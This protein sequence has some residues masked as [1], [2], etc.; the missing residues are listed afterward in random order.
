MTRHGRAASCAAALVLSF[1]LLAACHSLPAGTA[2]P[3]PSSRSAAVANVRN[4]LTQ[5]VL[6]PRVAVTARGIYVAW[7]LS[8]PG[9]EVTRSELARIN[10]ATGQVTASRTV[11]SDVVQVVAAAGSLWAA[12]QLAGHRTLL[13]LDPVTLASTGAWTQA[14]TA[15]PT[16]GFHLAVAESGLW[17]AAANRLIR[18]S[19]PA[20][21]PTTTIVLPGAYSSDVS[22]NAAGTVLIV[23]EADSGGRGSVQR[24]D[25]L[26]GR[27]LAVHPVQG[28]A[29]PAV[30]GPAGSS[31]WLSEPTGMQGYVQRLGAATLRPDRS[32]C[33]EG[34]STRTCVD[35]TNGISASLANGLLWV[36]Q[37]AGGPDRNYCADPADGRKLASLRLPQPAQ[38]D[39]LAIGP[40]QVFYSALGPK[41]SLYLREAPIPAACRPRH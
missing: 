41:A 8:P 15:R 10:P 33:S 36:T 35:G 27:L 14:R 2:T 5:P 21:R 34:R 40:D 3:A 17:V 29:A 16:W 31:V 18:L 37:I 25:A 38:D 7:Q 19:L 32:M 11:N 12:A 39:V 13:R 24:R 20:A 1:L 6:N 26:T 23:S 4:V 22:A 30:A 28:V 9:A